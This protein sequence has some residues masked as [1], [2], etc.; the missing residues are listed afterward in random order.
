MEQLKKLVDGDDLGAT[1]AA[2]R[3]AQ[4]KVDEAYRAILEYRDRQISAG[5]TTVTVLQVTETVCFTV[6]AVAGGAV[7]AA[8]V[9]AGGLG[10]GVVSSGAIMGGGTALLTSA[11]GVGAKA[12]YGDEVG[13]QDVKNVAIDTVV[14]AAGGAAGSAVAAKLAPFLA[15]ALTKSLVANG[16]FTNVAEE[17]LAKAV[18]AVVAGS[19]GGMVQGAITDGVRVLR[20]QATMEQLLR[21]VVINLIAGGIAGLVGHHLAGKALPRWTRDHNTADPQRPGRKSRVGGAVREHSQRAAARCRRCD[22]RG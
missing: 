11:S 14:G 18:A 19:A 4:E 3:T 2:T 1:E 6:F 16:L 12:Y 15:P 21:N 10:L 8:A 5:K 13:W 17:T 9:A 22:H 20:G 7:L